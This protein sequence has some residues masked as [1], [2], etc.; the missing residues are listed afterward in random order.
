MSKNGL[1]S[2]K[3]IDKDKQTL[4]N[5]VKTYSTL[6]S[7][8]QT[9]HASFRVILKSVFNTKHIRKA[10]ENNLKQNLNET[11]T[12]KFVCFSFFMLRLPLLFS[13]FYKI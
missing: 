11:K 6:F 3:V 8:S 10:N 4:H 12:S 9:V 1:K 7:K 5:L 2:L 13:L